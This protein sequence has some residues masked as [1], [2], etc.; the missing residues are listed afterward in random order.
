MNRIFLRTC[1]IPVQLL[2]FKTE[3]VTANKRK[4][5]IATRGCDCQNKVHPNIACTEMVNCPMLL[6]SAL[7]NMMTSK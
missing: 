3:S 5:T 2:I 1:I 6:P 7:S 4:P